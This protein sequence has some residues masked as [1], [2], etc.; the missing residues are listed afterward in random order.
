MLFK[1]ISLEI[2]D[3]VEFT[4]KDNPEIVRT[5]AVSVK[6][7]NIIFV[8]NRD[9]IYYDDNVSIVLYRDFGILAEHKLLSIKRICTARRAITRQSGKYC[10]RKN[11]KVAIYSKKQLHFCTILAAFDEIMYVKTGNHY[12][13]VDAHRLIK[14]R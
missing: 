2:G 5:A 1:G 12:L 9:I 6:H 4:T 14:L 10:F 8:F 3:I 11:Q 7:D 13:F